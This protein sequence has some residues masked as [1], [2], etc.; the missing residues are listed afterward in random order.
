M[1]GTQGSGLW[2]VRWMG[3]PLEQGQQ[4]KLSV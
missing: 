2:A 1:H 4:V 3:G